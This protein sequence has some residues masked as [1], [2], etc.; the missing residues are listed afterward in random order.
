MFRIR[1]LSDR[2]IYR[3]LELQIEAH[4]VS[5]RWPPGHKL[6]SV[7]SLAEKLVINPNTV[8]RAYHELEQAG[9]VVK[10]DRSGVYVADHG[11]PFRQRERE[12]RLEGAA[13]TYLGE[14]EQLGFEL[15]D[16]QRTLADQHAARSNEDDEDGEVA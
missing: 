13:R 15:A 6:P 8:V 11:S 14:G 10:R 16:M 1:P 4:I 2:P 5:G 3:Q 9:L 12:E 7:R